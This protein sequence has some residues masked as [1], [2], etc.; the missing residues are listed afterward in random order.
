MNI[1]QRLVI[2]MSATLNGAGLTM[3]VMSVI[4]GKNMVY[5][6][7]AGGLIGASWVMNKVLWDM[8]K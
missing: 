1:K 2:T 7:V 8:V 4:D 6:V 3:L 5:L